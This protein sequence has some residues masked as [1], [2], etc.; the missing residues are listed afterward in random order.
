MRRRVRDVMV[1]KHLL[2]RMVKDVKALLMGDE[3]GEDEE[4]VVYLWDTH[5]LMANGLNYA[6]VRADEEHRADDDG[7]MQW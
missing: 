6:D 5:G 3:Q 4:D 1:E 2:E 7:V